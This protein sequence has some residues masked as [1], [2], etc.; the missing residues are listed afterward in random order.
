V[1]TAH[2]PVA[3]AAEPESTSETVVKK[4]YD[5]RRLSMVLQEVKTQ[6]PEKK[7]IL[8]LSSADVDY[9]NLVSTMDTIKSYKTV[10]VADLVEVELFPDVSL[11]DAE[12]K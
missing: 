12:A 11:G 7:D 10:V 9:Q 3:Q 1:N 4:I 5:Y 6:L 2:I 8:L